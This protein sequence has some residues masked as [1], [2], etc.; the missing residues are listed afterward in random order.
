MATLTA[1][2]STTAG[3]VGAVAALVAALAG[4]AAAIVKWSRTGTRLTKLE[5]KLDAKLEMKLDAT[6]GELTNKLAAIKK[7]VD[8]IDTQAKVNAEVES[9]RSSLIPEHADAAELEE[10]QGEVETLKGALSQLGSSFTE[11]NT[12]L[13]LILDGKVKLQ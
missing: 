12:T 2:L 11:I 9:V 10:L 6:L 4:L 13:R 8:R 7:R 3:L 1:L 5:M